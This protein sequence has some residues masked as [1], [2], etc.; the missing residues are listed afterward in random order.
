MPDII[1]SEVDVANS[2]ILHMAQT[3]SHTVI[4]LKVIQLEC[5]VRR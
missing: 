2:P 5:T 1:L 3:Y 4:Q